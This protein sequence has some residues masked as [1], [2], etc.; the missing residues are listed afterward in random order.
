MR[1]SLCAVLVLCGCAILEPDCDS[2]ISVQFRNDGGGQFSWAPACSISEIQVY[3][4]DTRES[5]WLARGRL[6]SPVRYGDRRFT[7]TQTSATPL[8]PGILYQA[9]FNKTSGQRLRSVGYMEFVP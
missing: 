4:L 6:S 3:R 8:V 1:I 7:L 5:T 9:R 2:G